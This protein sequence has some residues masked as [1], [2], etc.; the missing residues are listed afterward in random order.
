MGASFT[1]VDLSAP[2]LA[3][4][5]HNS[6]SMGTQ[7]ARDLGSLIDRVRQASPCPVHTPSRHELFISMHG[8]GFSRTNEDGTMDQ[9]F[10]IY[11]PGWEGRVLA[12][13]WV[14]LKNLLNGLILGDGEEPDTTL[15]SGM[16]LTW[17][18]TPA[19]RDHCSN[20]WVRARTTSSA[21][22]SGDAR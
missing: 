13:R 22:H 15:A 7:M 11:P 21:K 18:A 16:I 14:D 4:D 19:T 5:P 2:N 9:G 6:M 20:R 10:E 12:Y 17:F 1:L 8:H 3:G